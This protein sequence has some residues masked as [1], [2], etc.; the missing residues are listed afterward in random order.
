MIAIPAEPERTMWNALVLDVNETLLDLSALDPLFERL[1]GSSD[2]RPDW[3]ARVLVS[4]MTLTACGHYRPFDEV[5]A[6]ALGVTARHYGTTLDEAAYRAVADGMR[7]L[8]PHPEVPEALA[9]LGAA[10]H[11]LV[12]LS[13]SRESV[14]RAQLANAGLDSHFDLILS[15]ETAGRLKPAGAGYRLAAER[16]QSPPE[17]LLM[18]AA[19]GWDLAGAHSAGMDTALVARPGQYPDPLF[20][21]PGI[22]GA[23]L[24]AVAREVLAGGPWRTG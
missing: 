3:F 4:A 9:R 17:L 6:A 12:A 2:A 7:R 23:D 21:A 15:V 10:G 13:N 8:P 18:I 5:A 20:P 1:L 14:L 11:P 19:H 24:D 16:L 22:I